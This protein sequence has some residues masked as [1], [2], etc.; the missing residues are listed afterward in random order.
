MFLIQTRNNISPIG[1]AQFDST[2]FN[3]SDTHADPHA[4]VLR[5]ASL[6]GETFADSLLAVARAGAGTNNIPIDELSKKGVVVFNTPGA[7]ANAVK[8]LVIAGMLLASRNL[9]EA[10]NYSRELDQKGEALNKAVEA[11][12]KKFAG[13]ELTGRTLGIIGLGAIGVKV[14]NTAID[15]GMK[16]CCYD[17]GLTLAHAINLN[18][19]VQRELKI[20]RVVSQAEFISYHVPLMEST[21]GIFNEKTLDHLRDNCVLLNFSRQGIIDEQAVL[22]GIASHKIRRF[23]TDFPSERLLHEPSVLSMPHLG[24]STGE[25]E[26]TC[27]LMAVSQ[28]QHFISTGNIHNAVNLP[29]CELELPQQG[30]RIVVINNNVPGM[31]EHI[32]AAIAKA[33]LNIVDLL[34]QSRD[35]LACTIIDVNSNIDETSLHGISAIP[36]VLKVRICPAAA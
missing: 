11:G 35:N 8:E 10:C 30:T 9:L 2:R 33:S 25:A 26:D 14:A 27:A 19:A 15:L 23:V 28:L 5:S 7:N 13:V 29:R 1:L 31:I 20:E 34:N 36:G 6:H 12:K 21:R 22:A 3:V 16:V 17:P 24:A 32:T 18:P 4:I